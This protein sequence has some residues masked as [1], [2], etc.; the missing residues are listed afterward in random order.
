MSQKKQAIPVLATLLTLCAVAILCSLG[1]WQVQRLHWKEG[2]LAQLAAA[3]AAGP[4]DIVFPAITPDIAPFY[5]HLRGHYEGAAF[6]VGPRTWQGAA[7]SHLVVPLMLDNGGVVF[8]NRGWVP[9]GQENAA[10]APAGDV[11]VAGLLRVPERG[12]PF[13]PANAPEKGAWFRIDP[14][15]MAA[16]AGIGLVAPLVLYAESETP[17]GAS[18]QPVRAAL[19]SQPPNNHFQYAAFWFSMAGVLLVIYYLRFWHGRQ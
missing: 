13:V 2:I 14:A 10:A 8:V 18:L 1:A 9:Q 11:S 5:A 15:Q 6:A 17:E 4:Q 7:G 19:Q 16:A 12:N 3:R